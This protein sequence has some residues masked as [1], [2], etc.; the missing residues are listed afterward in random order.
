MYAVRFTCIAVPCQCFDNLLLLQF[1]DA[2]DKGVSPGQFVK[3][4]RGA[5]KLISG[6][7]EWAVVYCGCCI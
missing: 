3:D 2:F 4:M 6:I 7:G 5:N 1:S